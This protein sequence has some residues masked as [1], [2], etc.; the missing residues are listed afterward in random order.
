MPPQND[1]GGAGGR[2]T[3]ENYLDD[4]RRVADIVGRAPTRDE[5]DRHGLHSPMV[6]WMRFGSWSET[7]R[8]AGLEPDSSRNRGTRV[9]KADYLA[10]VR[11][12]ADAL[13]RVPRWSD[14][15]EYG[16]YSGLLGRKLFGGWEEVL[17]EAG[18]E[19][20]E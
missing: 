18:L 19:T 4:V 3:D 13:G 2:I 6:G 14:M 10:E 12:L 15:D 17:S 8:E 1:A 7:L 9:D 11:R 20:E 16:S 5:F